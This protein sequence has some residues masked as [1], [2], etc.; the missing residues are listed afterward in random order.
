MIQESQ[1]FKTQII[2][3]LDTLPL[4]NLKLLAEFALF[5]Q[6]RVAYLA[7]K[8]GDIPSSQSDTPPVNPLLAYAGQ[9]HGD[10]IE[11]C[12]VEVLA[13]RSEAEF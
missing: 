13:T 12:L 1:Q 6:H 4:A 2:E 9:W 7:E 8:M 10:D 11:D 3:I 5:L